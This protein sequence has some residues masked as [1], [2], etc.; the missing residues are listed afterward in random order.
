MRFFFY[1]KRWD[2]S[3]TKSGILGKVVV[4]QFEGLFRVIR[5]LLLT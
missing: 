4:A 3:A 2:M 1:Y 5:I